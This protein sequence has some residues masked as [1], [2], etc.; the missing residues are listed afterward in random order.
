MPSFVQVVEERK[1]L[2]EHR[3]EVT[4]ERH[5][6]VERPEDAEFV[7]ALRS[8]VETLEGPQLCISRIRLGFSSTT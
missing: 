6:V 8:L 7:D 1:D 2:E 4:T 3:H 5:V